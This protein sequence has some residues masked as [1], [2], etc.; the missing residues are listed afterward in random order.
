MADQKITL[1]AGDTL[2]I[3]VAEAVVADP[4]VEVDTKTQSGVEETFTP[5]ADLPAA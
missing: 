2:E 5:E 1:N 4:V 3:T